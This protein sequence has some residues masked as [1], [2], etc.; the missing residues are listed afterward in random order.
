V[1]QG[2]ASQGS[3]VAV[4]RQFLLTNCHVVDKALSIEG[5]DGRERRPLRL[6][7]ADSKTDRCILSTAR[8]DLRP[9]AG[10]RSAMSV[11]VGE[12]VYTIGNPLGLHNTLSEGLVSGIRKDR[13]VLV[14]Q[15]TAPIAPGSSG[16]GLFDADGRLLGITTFMLGD[17]G[18]LNFAIAAEEYSSLLQNAR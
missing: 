8:A 17:V 3:A 4:T 14:I 16:G 5:F 18:S 2:E 10:T 12:T 6:V 7:A 13:S 15:T 1:P 9:V 11:A